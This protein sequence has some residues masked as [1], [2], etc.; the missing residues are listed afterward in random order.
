[1]LRCQAR[2]GRVSPKRAHQMDRRG[3]QAPRKVTRRDGHRMRLPCCGPSPGEVIFLAMAWP[4]VPGAYTVGDPMAP[5]AVCTLTDDALHP[6]VATSTGIAIAGRLNTAN[7]G[8]EDLIVNVTANPNIRFL[9]VCG[10]ESPVFRQGQPLRMLVE[11][12]TTADRRVIGAEGYEPLLQ[13]V[14]VDSVMQFRHQI[15]L[16]DRT[17]E[18]DPV[19]I[20]AT[21]RELGARSAGPFA[22][23]DGS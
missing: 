2:F 23:A 19:A 13:N 9:V 8:I 10:K 12:G 22:S 5:V 1:M 3:L 18:S 15:E 7:L 14:P 16:F 11:N 21:A 6:V 17:G 4:V 20:A